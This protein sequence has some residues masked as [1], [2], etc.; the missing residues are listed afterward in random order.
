LRNPV[1]DEL[2][3]EDRFNWALVNPVPSLIRSKLSA[4]CRPD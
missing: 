2:P 3:T 4:Q 1:P